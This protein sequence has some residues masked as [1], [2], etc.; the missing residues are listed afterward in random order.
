MCSVVLKKKL[1]ISRDFKRNTFFT[2]V[3]RCASQNHV[4]KYNTTSPWQQ[5]NIKTFSLHLHTFFAF[6]FFFLKSLFDLTLFFCSGRA[7][8]LATLFSS[9][10]PSLLE[11]SVLASPTT[12]RSFARSPRRRSRTRRRLS[13]TSRSRG[14]RR[15]STKSS[16]IV[17]TT[18]SRLV[19]MLSS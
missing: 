16:G 3:S 6:K 15:S 13:S 4:I 12:R 9:A 19:K 8:I 10:Q 14:G 17:L 5:G 2:L 11:G 18:V 7:N 1:N